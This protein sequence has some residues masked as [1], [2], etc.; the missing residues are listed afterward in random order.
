MNTKAAAGNT[1]V[2]KFST[3]AYELVRSNLKT[4]YN[5]HIS[6]VAPE[7]VS[8]DNT[9]LQI[10]ETWRVNNR[11]NNGSVGKT[12]QFTINFYHTKCTMLVNWKEATSTFLNEHLPKM[13]QSIN[14]NRTLIEQLDQEITRALQ[15]YK[16]SQYDKKSMHKR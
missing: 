2:I 4:F 1:V 8:R 15:N 7:T 13:R 6:Y 3:S 12:H 10:D 11:L 16:S 9:N 5:N 14:C